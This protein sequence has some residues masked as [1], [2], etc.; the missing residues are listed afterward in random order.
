MPW[1][2]SSG[3]SKE[4]STPLTDPV[5]ELSRVSRPCRLS[6]LGLEQTGKSSLLY[7]IASHSSPP[8]QVKPELP[9]NGLYLDVLQCANLTITGLT[10]GL[11]KPKAYT[12]DIDTV[13]ANAAGVIFMVDCRDHDMFTAAREE[14][15]ALVS[16]NEAL[17]NA[18]VLVMA[19]WWDAQGAMSLEDVSRGLRKG[20]PTTG[21]PVLMHKC[22]ALSGQGVP[23]AL[24]LLIHV[25]NANKVPTDREP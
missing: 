13:R 23:E 6:L 12:G 24:G 3:V 9:G 19:N 18:P 4:D 21:Q 20:A 2:F 14:F 10:V 1:P 8:L 22:N 7:Y 16:S 5:A 11:N 15:Y 25:L 17:K